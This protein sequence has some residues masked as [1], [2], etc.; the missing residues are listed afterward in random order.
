M[1]NIIQILFMLCPIIM[2]GQNYRWEVIHGVQTR[3]EGVHHAMEDYDQ[4]LYISGYKWIGYEGDGWSIKTDANGNILYD[5]K[6]T[7][8]QY[9][10]GIDAVANDSHGNKYLCGTFWSDQSWPYLIKLDSCANLVWCRALQNENFDFGYSENVLVNKNNQILLQAYYAN[11]QNP[12]D[13]IHIIAFDENGNKLWMKPYAS[14]NDHPMLKAPDAMDFIEFN[15][16]YYI[17]GYCYYP[18]PENPSHLWRRPMFIGID[19]LFNEKFVLPFMQKD[20]IF[21]TAYSIIP[22]NDSTLLGVGSNFISPQFYEI[23]ASLMFINTKGEEVGLKHLSNDAIGPEIIEIIP[24]DVEKI[25]DSLLMTLSDYG[26]GFQGT[27]LGEIVMDTSGNIYKYQSDSTVITASLV[28]T[29]D[30]NFLKAGSK[31]QNNSTWKDICL[32]KINDSLESV[33]FDTTQRVYDSLCPRTI[34]SGTIDLTACL[35]IVDIG[36]LPT[37]DQYYESIRW[38]PLKAFPNPVKDGK[39]TLEFEN[40]EHHQNMV[41]NCYDDFGRQIHSQKVYKGQQDTDVDVSGWSPGIYVAVVYSNGGARGKV[42]F[43]VE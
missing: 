5:K 23:A 42:K 10:L 7:H 13:R 15:N 9:T 28:K 12:V 34:Q 20:S 30:N 8:S 26:T 37:P 24:S 35:T 41:L 19:S 29:Y 4:G 31:R 14:E 16:N 32:Y 17:T 40:T 36:E 18:F 21:G 25:N 6:H 3:N 27:H 43:V 33:P 1:K 22:I 39:L 2:L 38:I 11:L